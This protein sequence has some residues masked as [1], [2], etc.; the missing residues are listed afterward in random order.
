ME[1]L[2]QLG[3]PMY[4]DVFVDV[5]DADDGVVRKDDNHTELIVL[6]ERWKVECKER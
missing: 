4:I 1:S 5:S 6:V 2:W 3:V